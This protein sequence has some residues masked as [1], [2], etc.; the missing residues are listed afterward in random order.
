M[1]SAL[2]QPSEEG[3]GSLKVYNVNGFTERM[4][5]G[6]ILGNAVESCIVE[7]AEECSSTVGTIAAV[8]QISIPQ[9]QNHQ[10]KPWEVIGKP[11][12][13]EQEKKLLCDFV[14]DHHNVFALQDTD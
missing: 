12:L 14:M 10:I 1:E 3:L 7:P 8:R 11:T 13:S 9:E 5:E 6:T 4:E 2:F